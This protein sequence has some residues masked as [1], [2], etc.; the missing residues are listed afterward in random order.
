MA[1][2]FDAVVRTVGRFQAS[3]ERNATA[4]DHSTITNTQSPKAIVSNLGVVGQLP[5]RHAIN[6]GRNTGAG[7]AYV[8]WLS[9][10]FPDPDGLY[11]TGT[12]PFALL[13]DIVGVG[14]TGF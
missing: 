11:Y 1:G 12:V 14:Y 4:V 13:T 9:P 7:S 6:R 10:T 3:Q 5:R 2:P 8:F